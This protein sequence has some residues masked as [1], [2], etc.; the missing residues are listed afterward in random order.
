VSRRETKS[1]SSGAAISSS[2]PG[3]SPSRTASADLEKASDGVMRS[4]FGAT[5][6]KCSACS[7]VYVSRDVR[8]IMDEPFN[9]G[10]FVEPTVIAFGSVSSA[11]TGAIGG[12]LGKLTVK[13]TTQNAE[14]R[15]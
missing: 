7:R 8:R 14:R 15:T 5:G 2:G 1:A 6:Q 11:V 4:S 13:R 12:F 9:H 3:A 10:Y